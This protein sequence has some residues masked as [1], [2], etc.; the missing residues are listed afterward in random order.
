MLSIAARQLFISIKENKYHRSYSI[1]SLLTC[2]TA[3]KLC[4]LTC[5][6]A[7]FSHECTSYILSHSSL[8]AH[9]IALHSTAEF[10]K[11][12]KKQKLPLLYFLRPSIYSFIHPSIYV[13]VPFIISINKFI[14]IHSLSLTH[15]LTRNKL[16]CADRSIYTSSVRFITKNVTTFSLIHITVNYKQL[17]KAFIIP[18]DCK[19][20]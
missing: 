4:L 8:S 12:N 16:M 18:N 13:T 9:A 15:S 20:F 2:L 6:T 3:F 14:I 5:L 19:W 17:E 11:R 1:R 7:F 10:E